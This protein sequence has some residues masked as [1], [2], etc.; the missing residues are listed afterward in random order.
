VSGSPYPDPAPGPERAPRSDGWDVLVIGAGP[1]GS[2]VA[3]LLAQRGL[4]VLVF[5]REHFPRFHIGESLLPAGLT[6]LERLGVE[7]EERTFVPKRGARFL[8]EA[9]GRSQAFAFAESLEGGAR[10]AWH[11]DRARFDTQLRDRARAHGATVWHGVTVTAAAAEAEGAWVEAAGER[12]R[13]RYLIDASGQSRLCARR[14]GTVEPLRRFGSTAVFTHYEGL[15]ERAFATLG[16]DFDIRILVRNDGWGWVI[17]LSERRL[18][19]GLVSSG[20]ATPSMLESGLL[21]GPLVRGLVAGARRLETHVVADFSYRNTRPV[22]PRFAAVGDAAC[23][24]DPVF[25]SGVTLALR[26]AESVADRVGPALAQGREAEPELLAEHVQSMDRAYR[27]FAGLIDRFYN[28]QI[29]QTLFLGKVEGMPGRSG[30]MSV[31]AG[32]VWRS[33]NP[34]QEMLLGAKRRPA[35][36]RS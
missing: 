32:D 12:F 28:T 10:S 1:G 16:P 11:V 5:E 24:L 21:D 3:G 14:A 26:A 36:A 6:V 18:S 35:Q 9:T 2:A 8:C 29:A 23:F 19:V 27:T 4:A 7:P 31:L 30:V 25:S 13:G 22:G 34:F 20:R 33:D 17:P 15:G